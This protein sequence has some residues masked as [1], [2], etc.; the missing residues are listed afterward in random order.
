MFDNDLLFFNNFLL[1]VGRNR[2][3]RIKQDA[4]A[5]LKGEDMDSGPDETDAKSHEGPE[6]H[7]KIRGPQFLLLALP[8][9]SRQDD[10]NGVFWD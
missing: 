2:F 10:T 7:R 6:I 1:L 3:L 8:R 5:D 4:H 9:R